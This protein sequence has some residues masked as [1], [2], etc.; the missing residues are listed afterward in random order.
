MTDAVAQMTDAAAFVALV[1]SAGALFTTLYTVRELRKLRRLLELRLAEVQ[2]RVDQLVRALERSD[3]DV[4]V[5]PA[6]LEADP[7][8]ELP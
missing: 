5:D 6:I 7:R 3:S 2:A 1:A 8:E 4:P